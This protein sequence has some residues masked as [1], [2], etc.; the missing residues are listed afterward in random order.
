[1]WEISIKR[2]R[3]LL[4]VPDDLETACRG[5]ASSELPIGWRHARAAGDSGAPRR[6]FDRMLVAQAMIDA[7]VIVTRDR[8]ISRYGVRHVIAGVAEAPTG[9]LLDRQSSRRPM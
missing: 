8:D 6:S 1:M 5:W 3:G 9:R 4:E 7:L 2:A